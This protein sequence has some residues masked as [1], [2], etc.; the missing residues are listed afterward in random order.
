[1]ALAALWPRADEVH[2]RNSLPLWTAPARGGGQ[3]ISPTLG[4]AWAVLVGIAGL[5]AA[6]LAVHERRTRLA[7]HTCRDAVRRA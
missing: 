4:V 1:M 7:A 6:A 5:V 3:T 2:V